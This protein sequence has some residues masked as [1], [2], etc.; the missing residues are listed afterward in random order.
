MRSKK[1]N[2]IKLSGIAGGY[3]N[4]KRAKIKRNNMIYSGT[5]YFMCKT[6]T[7]FEY[8]FVD[9]FGNAE[10]F[11]SRKQF[12]PEITGNVVFIGDKCFK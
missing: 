12:A 11:K 1:I 3:Y 10:I 8:D 7:P 2:F 5:F 4:F 6:L 9:T